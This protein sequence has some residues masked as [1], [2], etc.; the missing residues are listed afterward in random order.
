MINKWKKNFRKE[1]QARYLRQ[2]IALIGYGTTTFEDAITGAQE[3]YGMF[4]RNVP[5][6]SL[7]SW[8][9]T[10][11]AQ[12]IVFEAS[13]RFFTSKRDAPDMEPLPISPQIDPL[14]ILEALKKGD[15]LHGEENEVSYYRV[16][17]NGSG[18]GKTYEIHILLLPKSR[19]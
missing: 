8:G 6:E 7:E 5:D 4:D 17:E 12:G 10:R 19:Y 2:G 18:S 15:F 16:H 11:S 1:S 3:I 14:G 9:L 13:N